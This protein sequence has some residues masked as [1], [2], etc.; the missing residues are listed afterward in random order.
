M[1]ATLPP[2]VGVEVV[3]NNGWLCHNNTGCY[4]STYVEKSYIMSI[5]P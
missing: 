3:A 1:A 2:V 4:T 5:E